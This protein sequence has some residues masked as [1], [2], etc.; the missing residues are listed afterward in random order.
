MCDSNA[1][2]DLCEVSVEGSDQS[3][4]GLFGVVPAAGQQFPPQF[5][6]LGANSIDSGLFSGRFLAVFCLIAY[7]TT[8]VKMAR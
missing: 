1:T 7:R 3:V 6:D 5:A 8:E 2:P 4:P